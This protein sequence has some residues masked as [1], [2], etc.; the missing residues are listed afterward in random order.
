MGI[1]ALR[2]LQITEVANIL[3]SL[4]WQTGTGCLAPVVVRKTLIII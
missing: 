4:R 2:V 3:S 1:V